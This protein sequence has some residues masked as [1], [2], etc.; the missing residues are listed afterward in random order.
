M[1]QPETDAV[2]Q[3]LCWVEFFVHIAGVG[4]SPALFELLSRKLVATSWFG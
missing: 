1:F 3:P 4:R 2:V